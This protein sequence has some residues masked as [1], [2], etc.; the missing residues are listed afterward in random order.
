MSVVNKMLQDLEARKQQD[1]TLNADYQPPEKRQSKLLLVSLLL[2]AVIAIALALTDFAWLND[3]PQPQAKPVVE[4]VVMQKPQTPDSSANTGSVSQPMNTQPVAVF[5]PPVTET[6]TTVETNSAPISA[7]LPAESP[8]SE[9][10][11]ESKEPVAKLA[12]HLNQTASELQPEAQISQP[13]VP[14]VK[15]SF[16]M[17]DSKQEHK[18]ISLKQQIAESLNS[19]DINT[20]QT[21]LNELLLNEPENLKAR[22]KLASLYFSQGNYAQ[23]RQLLV[24]GIDLHPNQADL[25]LMLARLYAVQKSPEQAMKI[26]SDFEPSSY[27]QAEYL[28]YRAALAQQLNKIE[29]A[30]ADY[31]TLTSIEAT[32]AKWLLGLAITHD[33]LGETA[34][35]SQA[36]AKAFALDQLDDSVNQF[37]QQRLSVLAGAQ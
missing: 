35:A 27:N 23:T 3:Q 26:L 13:S 36:Y 21:L 28:A 16:S 18:A 19:N 20:A 33:K 32:N 10:S 11:V 4:N 6:P 31:L 17:S 9:S 5:T 24:R 1:E 29:L 34:A 2:L 15:P 37:I 22:K 30:K 7:S 14:V 8:Q 12:V 25:R